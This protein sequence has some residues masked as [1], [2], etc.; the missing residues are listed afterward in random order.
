M[1]ISPLS[2]LGRNRRGM[3]VVNQYTLVQ[4]LGQGSQGVVWLGTCPAGANAARGDAA[5][6]RTPV[7][8]EPIERYAVKIVSRALQRKQTSGMRRQVVELKEVALMKLLQH[9]NLV[10]LHE[11]IDDPT[12]DKFFLC[13]DYMDL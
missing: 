12:G 4:K 8:D 6:L 3:L 11:V 1:R 9:S 2:F 7:P 13:Q 10:T 5:G